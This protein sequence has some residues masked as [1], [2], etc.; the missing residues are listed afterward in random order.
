MCICGEKH[1]IILQQLAVFL[2]VFNRSGD[3]HHI[4]TDWIKK[5]SIIILMSSCVTKTVFFGYKV[6][7]K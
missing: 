3:I 5:M 2:L 4:N 7:I 6:A 1:G